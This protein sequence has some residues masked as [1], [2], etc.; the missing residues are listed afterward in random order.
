M[1]K[2]LSFNDDEFI[3]SKTDLSGR[4]TYGNDLFITISGYSEK[5]LLG[6]PHNIL[7]HPDMPKLIFKLLWEHVQN[8]KEIFAYVKNRTKRGDFYWVFA[9][10]TPSYSSVGKIIGYHSVRRKP[11]PEALNVIQNQYRIFLDAEQ[12]GGIGASQKILD[13]NLSQLGVSY[14]QFILSL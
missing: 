2:E 14:D 8:G 10:V 13:S 12:Y 1:S 11:T 6:S 4:I 7:R 5:E 9:H 3:V